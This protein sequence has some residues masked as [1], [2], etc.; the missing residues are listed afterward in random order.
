MT[1]LTTSM[2]IV[3]V[4][5]LTTPVALWTGSAGA[6]AP[7]LGSGS[8]FP[9]GA[10]DLWAGDVFVEQGLMVEYSGIGALRGWQDF[11]DGVVDFAAT[12]VAYPDGASTP[13]PYAY[14]PIVAGGTALPYNLVDPAGNRITNLRLSSSTIAGLFFGTIRNWRDP[15]I[16]AENPALFDRMPDQEVRLAVRTAGAGTTG[17][18]TDYLSTTAPAEWQDFLTRS[19]AIPTDGGNFISDWPESGSL[20]N[21][22]CSVFAGSSEVANYIAQSTPS[23]HGA[24]G[25]VET[26][27]A[28][29]LGLPVASVENAAGSYRAP[30]ARNVAIALLE[31]TEN[32]DGTAHL[33]SVHT[34]PHEEAYPIS[35]Y[36]YLVI[37]TSL[38]FDQE[39]GETLSQY[40][41][42]SVTQ[43]Q[44][45]AGALGYSPLP[46]NL[47]QFAL[48]RVALINGHVEVPPLGDWGRTWERLI[49]DPAPS[50]GV[51]VAEYANA[52]FTKRGTELR[53]A[54]GEIDDGGGRGEELEIELSTAACTAR[55][56]VTTTVSATLAAPDLGDIVVDARAGNAHLDGTFALTGTRAATPAGRGCAAPDP[57]GAV[58]TPVEVPLTL[59]VDWRNERGSVPEV[60]SGEACGGD[61]ICYYRA[62]TARARWSSPTGAG[63]AGSASAFLFEGTYLIDDVT[64]AAP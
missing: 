5:A 12:D 64:S 38:D 42:Y 34:S 24:I 23:A 47:V 45:Y 7:I 32:A 48:D 8:T 52:T 36:T 46:P 15:A 9:E 61:G 56:L 60:Y 2:A 55:T 25:Y 14:V 57:S 63:G 49:A 53:V 21:C 62:A 22:W 13:R 16:L 10:L 41:I 20:F 58:T 54:P 35:S 50:T 29:T 18:F 3:A 51:Y 30:S 19:G 33:A 27:Y 11:Q 28:T 44:E 40:L 17:V 26:S 1:R 43:G 59:T 6:A 31:T 4:A 39:K 37:P